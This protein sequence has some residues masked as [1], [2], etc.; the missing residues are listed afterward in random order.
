MKFYPQANLTQG[1]VLDVRL[2]A[3][4]TGATDIVR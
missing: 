2:N 4:P 3:G 1:L